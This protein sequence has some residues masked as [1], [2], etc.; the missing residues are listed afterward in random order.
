MPVCTVTVYVLSAAGLLSTVKY[1]C[2]PDNL[3]MCA[4]SLY[5]FAFSTLSASDVTLL[6]IGLVSQRIYD[7]AVSWSW[8]LHVISQLSINSCKIKKMKILLY[9]IFS[10]Y[11]K[12]KAIWKVMPHPL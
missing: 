12:I 11:G 1:F 10:D 3:C 2:Q 7:C 6:L 8:S 9:P 4:V 5:L